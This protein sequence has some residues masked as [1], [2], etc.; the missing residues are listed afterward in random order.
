MFASCT[1][2]RVYVVML[3]K[4]YFYQGIKLA[5]MKNN[6]FLILLLL[7]LAIFSCRK[8]DDSSI[9]YPSVYQ[10][11]GLK[12]AGDLRIFSSNGEIRDPAARSRFNLMDSANF[13]IYSEYIRDNQETMSSI[14][15]QDPHHAIVNDKYIAKNCALT[16]ERNRLILTRADTSIG[17]SEADEFTRSPSYYLAQIKP[18]VYSEYL[19]SSTRGF[20]QFGYTGREKFILDRSTGKLAAPFIFF[21]LHRLQQEYRLN[22]NNNLQ[23]DFY[24]NISVGDTIALKEYL[25]LYEK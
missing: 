5:A 13:T 17:Y 10:K 21:T 3:Q 1:L 24:K 20:Y 14:Q 11:S 4:S 8:N 12:S 9:T 16:R 7:G 22:V 19:I 15:L 23:E 6:K 2:E 18:E 25:V